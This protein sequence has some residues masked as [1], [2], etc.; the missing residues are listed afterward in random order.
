VKTVNV[1]KSLFFMLVMFHSL[2]VW[3]CFWN[4]NCGKARYGIKKL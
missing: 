3:H 2:V 1:L 4:I